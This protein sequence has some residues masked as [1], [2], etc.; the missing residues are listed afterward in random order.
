MSQ[1]DG[2]GIYD[3]N[4]AGI[5]GHDE[6][7]FSDKDESKSIDLMDEDKCE[8]QSGS[9]TCSD[10]KLDMKEEQFQAQE[11]ESQNFESGSQQ[12]QEQP[13]DQDSTMNKLTSVSY[14][15]VRLS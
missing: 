11:I 13:E 9:S 1:E 7:S 5:C 3:L 14:Y 2:A 12:G 15:K 6:W 8:T 4:E 10:F